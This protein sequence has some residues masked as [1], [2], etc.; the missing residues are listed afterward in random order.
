M[1]QGIRVL[2]ASVDDVEQ[3]SAVV[4]ASIKDAAAPSTA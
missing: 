1:E 4:L 3:R 2:R